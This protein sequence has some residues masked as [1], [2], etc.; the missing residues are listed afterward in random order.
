MR[1]NYETATDSSTEGGAGCLPR[2]RAHNTIIHR[3]F[4][5][6]ELLSEEGTGAPPLEVGI[7]GRDHDRGRITTT[8]GDHGEGGGVGGV[9]VG[10]I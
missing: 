10:P 4:T 9:E 3:G 8:A 1:H 6:A 5:E 7:W 2:E